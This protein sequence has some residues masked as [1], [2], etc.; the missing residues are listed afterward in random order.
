SLAVMLL[1][2]EVCE[3]CCVCHS[4]ANPGDNPSHL[5]SE[6]SVHGLRL[7]SG[8]VQLPHMALI[9]KGLED[10]KEA[11]FRGSPDM[12]VETLCSL[13]NIRFSTGA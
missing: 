12:L 11:I 10:S 2:F 4:H 7:Y 3:V 13:M 6:T 5:F 9:L 8:I 1:P